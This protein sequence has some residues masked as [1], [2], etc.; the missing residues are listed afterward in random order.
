MILF[1]AP[2]LTNG[3]GSK[4]ST[5]KKMLSAFPLAQAYKYNDLLKNNNKLMAI[6]IH[7]TGHKYFMLYT[8]NTYLNWV[9]WCLIVL[10]CA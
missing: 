2:T 5:L 8:V 3:V 1:P 10:F 6:G 9:Q 4:S 7:P